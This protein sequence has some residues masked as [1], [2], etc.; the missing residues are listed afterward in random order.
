MKKIWTNTEAKYKGKTYEAKYEYAKGDR[1]F[2]MY[3]INP[4][5]KEKPISYNS[6]QAAK[7]D[8]WS[9]NGE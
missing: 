8:G 5:K 1:V 3:R 9:H 4:P 7:K 2:Q 6:W